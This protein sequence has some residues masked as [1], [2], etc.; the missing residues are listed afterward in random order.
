MFIRSGLKIV[1]IEDTAELNIPHENVISSIARTGLGLEEEGRKRGS[2]TLFDLLKASLRQRP[3]YII[4]GE[5][6]GEEA[7]FLFQAMATG[8]LGMA[9]IHGDSVSSVIHRL[10]SKPM[11]I[12]RSMLTSL[13]T[14]VVQRKVRYGGS[15]IRRSIEIAEMVGMDAVTNELLTNR[16]YTWNAKNDSFEF[17]GRSMKLEQ[18]R[19]HSGLTDDEIWH[20]IDI[21]KTILGYLVKKGIRYYQDVAN[22]IREFYNNPDR[23]YR[24]AKRGLGL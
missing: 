3:D 20:E 14:V 11:N 6:R 24:K 22:A 15:H 7:Y 9:T 1:S 16:V 10:E 4:V 13:D 12:P 8:H 5:I 19:D 17:L 23:M 2:V 18:I 21:R